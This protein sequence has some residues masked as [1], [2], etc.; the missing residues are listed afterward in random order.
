MM[1]LSA[2]GMVFSGRDRWR[3]EVNADRADYLGYLADLRG[4]VAKT[5]AAQR[6]S[7]TWCHPDPEALWTLVGGCR[8]WERRAT[9]SDFCE[10]RI[11]VG[12]QRLATRLVSSEVKPVE[13]SDPVTVTAL[14]RFLST[15]STV[16]DVPVAIALREP[17]A[18]VVGGDTTHAR[19]LLRA[20]ICQLAVLHSPS[21]LLI[22][23]VV[24]DHNRDHWDWLKWLPH[25]QHPR[26][27][28]A[29][30]SARMAY[31]SLA[32]AE[33]ALAGLVIK[34]A[35]PQLVLVVDSDDVDGGERVYGNAGVILLKI[36]SG[37]DD[38]ATAGVLHLRVSGNKL[39]TAL[40]ADGEVSARPDQT[41]DTAALACAQ[42]LAG[43]RAGGRDGFAAPGTPDWQDLLGIDDL[44]SS[45]PTQWWNS[46]SPRDRLRVPIGT[47]AAGAPLEL[48]IKEAA[49]KGMGPH[50]L[51]VGATGSGKSEF[52][53][54]VALGM[55][56]RHSPEALNLVLVDF[57]GGATF[58]GMKCQVLRLC[59]AHARSDLHPHQPRPDRPR[60]RRGAPTR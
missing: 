11:G 10:V 49:E 60:S 43:Y 21:L 59:Y 19:A 55:M 51:C 8:M 20:M 56:A 23:A 57:K 36:D 45:A 4:A 48:D 47:T 13:R 15:H 39:V 14:H 9:D 53:R 26:A 1:L 32:E 7:L 46:T 27:T 42:R 25:H 17:A 58:L 35:L 52:L 5:A 3:S 29:V 34:D 24:S 41:S 12:T 31:P 22:A 2:I 50:G 30:G 18:V 6:S 54:T 28:D 33:R 40:S 16:A 37:A 44:A 38:P